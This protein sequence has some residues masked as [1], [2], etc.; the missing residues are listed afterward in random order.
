V[1]VLGRGS[2]ETLVG[3]FGYMDIHLPKALAWPLGI[4]L[5][6]TAVA[7]LPRLPRSS[8]PGLLVFTG[9]VILAYLTF[10]LQYVQTQARYLFPALAPFCLM[11]V[12]GFE[13]LLKG[14]APLAF[15]VVVIGL[16]IANAYAYAYAILPGEFAT[17]IA[18]LRR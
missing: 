5:I 1:Y 16:I 8:R 7:G 6:V 13:R 10:N 18:A 3:V 14:R 17:R 11:A 15:G 12:L 9:L 2:L 4:A